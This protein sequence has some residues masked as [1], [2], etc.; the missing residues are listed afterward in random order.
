MFAALM[1]K[2]SPEKQKAP[3]NKDQMEALVG[4]SVML[5]H[6][7]GDVTDDELVA[8]EKM[9]SA[10]PKLEGM[11]QAI[12]KEIARFEK[13]FEAGTRM[14]V[15]HTL[16]EIS[17]VADNHDDAEEVMITALTIAE[18]DGNIDDNE[19]AM[20]EKTAKELGLSLK[21]YL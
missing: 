17:D 5:A 20:L 1:E 12:N 9:L 4:I 3:V 16:R 8:M 2:L 13:L 14:G 18:A 21:D 10:N 15:M 6:A 11:G 19:M 7:D